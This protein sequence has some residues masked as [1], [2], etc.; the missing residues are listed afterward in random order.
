MH[1]NSHDSLILRFFLISFWNVVALL[2]FQIG[3]PSWSELSYLYF[4]F[5]SLVTCNIK[6]LINQQILIKNL[7]FADSGRESTRLPSQLL[8]IMV[9]CVFIISHKKNSGEGRLKKEKVNVWFI[10]ENRSDLRQLKFKT[11]AVL[12][13][14][15]F[16]VSFQKMRV[17]SHEKMREKNIYSTL[18]LQ[19]TWAAYPELFY[20]PF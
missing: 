15:Y 13:D 7:Q 4:G 16:P 19:K 12:N 17:E 10:E 8:L 3:Q 11:W 9:F 1:E 18:K 2:V 6:V 14:F 20:T 5:S